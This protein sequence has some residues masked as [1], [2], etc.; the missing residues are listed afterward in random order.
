VL[1]GLP[2]GF[3]A[4]FTRAMEREPDR[5]FSTVQE[6]SDALA[7][8]AGITFR[9]PNSGGAGHPA[10]MQGTMP[11]P[12][13][14]PLGGPTQRQSSY[15]GSQQYPG[16]PVTGPQPALG[17]TQAPFTTSARESV[18]LKSNKGILIGTVGFVLLVAA[19]TV[20]AVKF[21]KGKSAMADSPPP[22]DSALAATTKPGAGLVANGS[23]TPTDTTKLPEPI[24]ATSVDTS[25]ANA[26]WKDLPKPGAGTGNVGGN[27]GVNVGAAGPGAPKPQNGKPGGLP[28]KPGTA[29]NTPPTPPTTTSAMPPPVPPIHTATAPTPP[30]KGKVEES[31]F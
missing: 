16:Q 23:Q 25:A 17:G 6:M 19:G 24:P 31:G 20:G 22:Q 8:A 11:L 18:P 3:D 30:P 12:P 26:K 29:G 9:Q 10:S 7:F 5:R 1:P 27:V 28:G 21:I 14:H 2:A 13:G 4:W 15:P